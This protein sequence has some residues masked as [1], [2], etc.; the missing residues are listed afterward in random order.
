[1]Y[2]KPIDG[3]IRLL[4]VVLAV[5][6]ACFAPPPLA[7]A[8]RSRPNLV[9]IMADDMG[10]SD[11]G[12]YGGEIRT[13]N[14]DRLAA[15]GLRFTHFYNTARCCPT[16]AALL[17]GLYPQQAGI[18]HMTNDRGLPGYRGRLGRDCVTIAEALARGG[19]RTLMSGKWHVSPFDFKTRRGSDPATWPLQR[20]F[21][22][23]YGTLAG[24][25]SYFN[26]PGLMRGNHP[27]QTNSPHYFYTDAVSDEA[28]RLE[29]GRAHV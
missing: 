12:C 7:G 17:T 19:Y 21:E 22:V 24:G 16:R 26:P 14:L 8:E 5:L 25:G 4:P 20:G 23:F 6:A 11:I 28:A 2:L 1:M 9:L 18:G 27:V 15:G 29:I 3:C 10:Y 13:P